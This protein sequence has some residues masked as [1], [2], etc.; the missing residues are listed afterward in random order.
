MAAVAVADSNVATVITKI[1]VIEDDVVAEVAVVAGGVD[2]EVAAMTGT[3]VGVEAAAAEARVRRSI[4]DPAEAEKLAQ[5]RFRIINVWRPINGR[6]ESL[7]L[8]FH[9][10]SRLVTPAAT[11]AIPA[12]LRDG[13]CERELVHMVGYELTDKVQYTV[14]L[15]PTDVSE[16]SLVIEHQ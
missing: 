6:V 11:Q 13:V 10:G 15:G 3:G 2:G 5:G 1:M 14:T 4:A 12:A 16:V 7:P 9:E 8:A